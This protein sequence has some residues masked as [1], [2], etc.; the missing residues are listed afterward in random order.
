M[1][2]EGIISNDTKTLIK[3]EMVRQIQQ[4][5]ATT[6]ERWERAVFATITGHS[7]EEIDW[8]VKDNHAGYYTWVKSFD[9]LVE[10]LIDDGY[11]RV[12]ESADA[13]TL[14]PAN[15]DPSIDYPQRP[16]PRG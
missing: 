5:G 11:V 3:S 1:I 13:R 10:E 15:V 9:A 16:Y 7:R 2:N 4:L 6:P 14:E 8:S 12:S